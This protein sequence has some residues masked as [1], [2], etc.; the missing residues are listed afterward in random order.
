MRLFVAIDLPDDIRQSVADTCRGLPGVRW[1]PPDQLHLTL[2]FI[3]EA[4]DAVDAA[5][6]SGL[7]I[8]TSPAFPLSLQGVGCFPSPRRPRVLWVGLNGGEPLMQLQ[9]EVE[10][11]VVTAGIPPE[12]RPFSPHIT[13]ARLKDHREGD[14][15]PFLARN[16]SFQCEPFTVDAFHLYSSIL[17][18]KGAIHRREASYPL[19]G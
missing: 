1:L 5:I 13:L 7:A 3:G 6:R 17:T 18:A 4:D 11:A 15:A 10:T 2:R 16:A 12:E 14:V 19:A 9:R 8:I